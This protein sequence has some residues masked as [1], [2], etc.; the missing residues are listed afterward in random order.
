MKKL[1]Q[2]T[3]AAA[4]AVIM[5]AGSFGAFAEGEKFERKHKGS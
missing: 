2:K 3:A 4:L 1:A 5:A